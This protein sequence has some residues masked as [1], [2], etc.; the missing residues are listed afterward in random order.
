M[1]I[2]IRTCKG[3]KD[4]TGGRNFWL[5]LNRLN[6]IEALARHVR[7]VVQDSVWMATPADYRTIRDGARYV[8]DLIPGAGTCLIPLEISSKVLLPP[9]K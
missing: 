9:V 6:D 8:L 4:Y 1:G 3:R 7:I 5:P 2:L